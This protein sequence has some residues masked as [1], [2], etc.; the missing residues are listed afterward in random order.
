MKDL[1]NLPPEEQIQVLMDMLE[2]QQKEIEVK[3]RIIG[4]QET[5]VTELLDLNEKLNNE[6][7]VENVQA[8]KSDLKQTKESLQSERKQ[9]QIEIG[10]VQGKLEQALADKEYAETHQKRIEVPVERRILY[11]KCC[12]C[13]QKA[14][15][16]SK[17]DYDRAWS[18]LDGEFRKRTVV[19]GSAFTG[20]VAYALLVTICM[21]I[22]TQ[23]FANDV[24]AFF[25]KI[26]EMMEEITCWI[27]NAGKAVATF[28]EKIAN[29]TA[30]TIVY[31]LVLIGVVVIFVAGIFAI[32]WFTIGWISSV[33]KKYCWDG[34]SVMVAIMSTAFVIFFGDMIK[35]L[36]PV[37][38]VVLLL[39]EQVIYMIIRRYVKGC[40][41]NRG[42][43]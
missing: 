27:L 26:W 2:E 12:N 35:N 33:Y 32:I 20:F 14:L 42:Y 17:E 11:E 39:L 25:R 21:A 19:C 37:N 1:A 9:H 31:W 15:E 22:R 41:E 5:Q 43:Y 6:N 18:R 30:S 10:D 28:S 16:K 23:S 29:A 7:S 36:F 4:E 38:Q 34:I 3:D 8:L 40:M 13:D 24:I